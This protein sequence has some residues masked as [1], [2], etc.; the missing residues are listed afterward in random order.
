MIKTTHF[1]RLS[2]LFLTSVL[3][4]GC[5]AQNTAAQTGHVEFHSPYL[6]YANNLLPIEPA[7]FGMTANVLE[8]IRLPA[9]NLH[10]Q[11][12]YVYD[13]DTGQ[14]LYEKNSELVRPI[15]SITKLMMAMVVLDADLDLDEQLEITQDDIDRIKHTRSRLRVGS[16][17]SRRELLHLALMSSENR[18]ASALGRNYPGGLPA[19]VRA[20]NDKALSLGM[21][22][23]LFVEPTGLSSENLSSAPD[24]AKMLAAAASYPLIQELSTSQKQVVHPNQGQT[25]QYVN[26]NRLVAN[27]QW[28]IQVSKTGFINEAG[29]C[30][31][32][33]TSLHGRNLAIVLL[34]A[35][36]RYSGMGDAGRIR[37]AL[38]KQPTLLAAAP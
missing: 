26:T 31:V 37:Q 15:A 33:H 7:A 18:A 25:L 16:Q 2:A 10:S 6:A 1:F 4:L 28:S 14:T 23:S 19:F 27:Q 24:L 5:A 30:L 22:H 36:G 12:A 17:L 21:R 13:L 3:S 29:R 20:M 8:Q 9:N 34:N 11:V 35:Q 38:E 32:L